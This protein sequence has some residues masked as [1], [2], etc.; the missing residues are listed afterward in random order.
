MKRNDEILQIVVH[1]EGTP[2]LKIS[3]K[4]CKNVTN[5]GWL[6]IV[7]K[8]YVVVWNWG[9]INVYQDVCY[10]HFPQLPVASFNQIHC[11]EENVNLSNYEL[12]TES[13]FK[14]NS[15]YNI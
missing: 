15:A 1:L 5:S 11:L 9:N 10:N 4:N 2:F 7:T 12:C 13:T 8:P 6:Q 3:S 14:N